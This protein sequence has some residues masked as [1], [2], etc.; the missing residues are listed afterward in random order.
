MSYDA[1]VE[2]TA[3]IE[4][5][6]LTPVSRLSRRRRFVGMAVDVAGDTAATMFLR[7]GVGCVH[8]EIHVLTRRDG[9]WHILGG[10][11]SSRAYEEDLLA[12]RPGLIPE[13][14][15]SPQHVLS[16]IDPQVMVAAGSG[17]QTSYRRGRAGF[18]PWRRRW[19][20]YFTAQAS[21]RVESVRIGDREIPVPWHGLVLIVWAGRG[22]PKLAAYDVNGSCLGMARVPN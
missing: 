1:Q 19:I 12:D 10:S 3:L 15:Q 7:R 6:T 22:S 16:G 5:R 9:Q 20:S 11:S 21:A 4:S 17:G 2:S 8:Q 13:V 14:L 18:C